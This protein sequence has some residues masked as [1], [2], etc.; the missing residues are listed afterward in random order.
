MEPRVE[1]VYDV[2]LANRLSYINNNVAKMGRQEPHS[3]RGKMQW[4]IEK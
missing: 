2:S 4:E 1:N 3:L